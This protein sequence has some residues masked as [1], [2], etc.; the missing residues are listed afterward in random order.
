M[1]NDKSPTTT[2]SSEP[3]TEHP[4]IAT[5][6]VNLGGV[7]PVI[8]AVLGTILFLDWAKAVML[9]LVASVLISYALDPLVTALERLRIPRPL[10]AGVVIL[11]MLTALSFAFVPLQKEAMAFLD[12]VPEAAHQ[13]RQ[14]SSL[15]DDGEEGVMEKA[16]KAAK[17]IQQIA[18]SDDEA[19][20][21]AEIP[22]TAVRVVERPF[23]INDFLIDSSSRALVLTTQVFSVL[24]L[25]YFVL[26]TGGLY[27]RKIVKMSGPSFH[28]MRQAVRVLNEFHHQVRRFIFVMLIGA[29]FV[30]GVT[31]LSFLLFGVEQP[32]FWG[33]VAGV[34]SAIPYLGPF[35]VFIGVGLAAFLQFGSAEAAVG[36]AVLSLLITSIQGNLLTPWMTSQ[37]SS[38]NTVA[39]FIGLLFW[40]WLWGPVG[41]IMA[42]PILMIA[43]TLCDH[44]ANLRPLG[45]L[46]GK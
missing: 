1:T 23:D 36:V 21:D 44:V 3:E 15:R 11:S 20:E 18:R 46:L 40:G 6:A 4:A 43:K 34:A 31:W 13:F 45:E 8:L 7:A 39:I 22:A 41:L 29:L 26:A 10:G 42:T 5:Q 27:K 33:V 28:G 19:P 35:L 37:I 17:E 14:N 38:L 25:V 30:G 24:L 16:Q 32:V 9:P 12:K 2:T